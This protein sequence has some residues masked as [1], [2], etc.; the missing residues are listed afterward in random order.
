VLDA[1]RTA[2]AAAQRALAESGLGAGRLAGLVLNHRPRA[3][4]RWLGGD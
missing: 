4:P 1:R 2:R 3:L